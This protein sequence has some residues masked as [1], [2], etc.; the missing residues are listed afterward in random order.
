MGN[1]SLEGISGMRKMCIYEASDSLFSTIDAKRVGAIR[2]E[3]ASGEFSRKFLRIF[4]RIF[5]KTLRIFSKIHFYGK[6][7]YVDLYVD[8]K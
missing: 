3:G 7:H 1:M 6:S 5:M 2:P 8:L 4:P